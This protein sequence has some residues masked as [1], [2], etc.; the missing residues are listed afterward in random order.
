[1]N[2]TI[3]EI[4]KQQQENII[5]KSQN[6]KK[7]ELKLQRSQIINEKGQKIVSNIELKNLQPLVEHINIKNVYQ[8]Q[9]RSVSGNE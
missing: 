7:V 9:K 1:M 8:Q 4:I 3:H 6:V 2:S 5:K